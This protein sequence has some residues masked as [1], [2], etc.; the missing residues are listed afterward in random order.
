[1]AVD[2]RL[3]QYSPHM[4]HTWLSVDFFGIRFEGLNAFPQLSWG[5]SFDEMTKNA[6]YQG[7][8]ATETSSTTEE[9]DGGS[10]E[11]FTIHTHFVIFMFW[12]RILGG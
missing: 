5:I 6:L 11:V 12:W 2:A 4:V 8:R 3:A 1:M 9:K 7:K 10:P